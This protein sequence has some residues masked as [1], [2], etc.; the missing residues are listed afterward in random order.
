MPRTNSVRRRLLLS[1]IAVFM[2]VSA[3]H[4]APANAMS[5]SGADTVRFWNDVTMS[6][7][8]NTAIVVP[9]Q[10]LYLT[11]VHRAIYDGVVRAAKAHVSIPAAATAAAH[12]V[13][14]HYF[15]AQ[16]AALDQRYAEALTTVP[17]DLSR[18]KGLTLG[19][20][21]ADRLLRA[22]ANDG[23]NGPAKPLPPPGPGV[24]IPT[25]PNA[26]GLASWLGDVKPFTLRSA[27]QFRPPAPPALTSRRWT[28][29]YNE[30]R[31]LGSANSTQRSA[32]QTEAARFWGD[33]PYA[34][35][36]RA[37]RAYTQLRGMG[38][39]RT[40]QLFALV[41]TAAADALIACWDAKFT[42]QFWRPFSAIPAGDTDGNPATAPDPAWQPLLVTPNHPE[43]PSAHGCST[44][45][46]FTVLAD[47][48]GTRH[49]DVDLDSV[50][51]GTTRHFTTVAELVREVGDARVWGGLH[52]RFSTDAGVR[53][54]RQVAKVV[55]ATD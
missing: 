46:M 48:V 49:I 16:Q 54:G 23:L 45:A 30:V 26:V 39:V 4:A 21:A 29:D 20:A 42:F 55:L 5:N 10:P 17:D 35:N 32:A 18:R 2:A 53:L 9:A 31:V 36:Q 13:L 28:V 33:P 22:R 6:T 51:T 47:L 52:W 8:V 12:S 50:L 14:L 24:W 34:Q 44:A 1:I 19:L 7:L 43:Y 41:D 15:P 3:V 11:Y 27:S 40:A 37:L 25:P 38:A